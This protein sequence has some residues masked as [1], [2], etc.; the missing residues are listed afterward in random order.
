M[1]FIFS[2]AVL[3]IHWFLSAQEPYA[4]VLDRKGGL[5]SQS[6]YDL[7]QDKT[8]FVWLANDLGLTRYD[9]FRFETFYSEKQSS[10]SG[11]CIQEDAFG[12]VWYENFD[13]HLYYYDPANNTLNALGDENSFGYLPYGITKRYVYH[14]EPN[15]IAAFDL[16]TLKKVK[17]LKIDIHLPQHSGSSNTNFYFIDN[18]TL[19]AVDLRLR[20][21]SKDLKFMEADQKH[22]Y[23]L[24]DT[25]L[26]IIN[27]FNKDGKMFL[28]NANLDLLTSF[29]IHEVS[30]VHKIDFIDD[31]IWIS[32]P[33]GVYVYDLQ[34][35]KRYHFFKNLSISCVIK[36]KQKNYW[37]STTNQGVRI[38]PQLENKFLFSGERLPSKMIKYKNEG[39]LISTKKGQVVHVDK[40]LNPIRTIIDKS[41][42]GEIFY[43]HYDEEQDAISYTGNRFYR[44][45]ATTLKEL[46]AIGTSVKEIL[47]IDEKYFAFAASNFSGFFT[48]NEKKGSD[49]DQFNV[50]T[51]REEFKLFL[52]QRTRSLAFNRKTKKIFFATNNGLYE[53]SLAGTKEIKFDNESFFAS[54]LTVF[55]GELYALSTKGNFYKINTDGSFTY[56]NSE[57]EVNEYDI[58]F[59]RNLGDLLVFASSSYVYQIS[60]QSDKAEIYNLN[61]SQYDINDILVD[62]ETLY[63]LINQGII[64]TNLNKSVYKESKPT[65]T[66]NKILAKDLQFLGKEII[67]LPYDFNAVSIEYS[68]LDFGKSIPTTLYYRVNES[69]WQKTSMLSRELTFPKLEPGSYKIDFKLKNSDEIKS[70]EFSI[71]LPWWRQW[72]FF[73][74][75]ILLIIMTL[76]SYYRSRLKSLSYKNQLLEENVKLEQNLRQSVLT[77]IKSQMNPHFLYNALNTIQAYIYSNDKENAGKYLIKFSKLTR[78]VLD[79]SEQETVGLDEELETLTLYLELEKARFDDD[80][81]FE[82][83]VNDLES[84]DYIRIPPMLI[85]PYVENAV[86]HGLLHKIGDKILKIKFVERNQALHVFVD[87]NGIGRKRSSEL[88]K[89]RN[90]GHKSFA[91]EANAKRLEVLNYGKAD[92]VSVSIEDKYDD[93]GKP[94]GTRVELRIPIN[95]QN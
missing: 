2:I 28:F 95:N 63:L 82:I 15:G 54:R 24:N 20:L 43:L 62:G 61:I 92:H 71:L 44:F 73:M 55:G 78:K 93:F 69:G 53:V 70:I 40:N 26:V 14:L 9:G 91:S 16:V 48:V 68:I 86:K 58:R 52:N 23:P 60:E 41:D 3:L 89:N 34:G 46:P 1:R 77:T 19:Y 32:S 64:K 67:R 22:I 76:Y 87:D 47:R 13:G 25:S 65:F 33:V 83:D 80:F 38:V 6:V 85:Q 36:D 84:Q 90:K 94:L 39:Y 30:L 31:L 59:M 27:K 45:N 18:H 21:K 12:R 75:V 10:F 11:S 74:L 8:G 88:N 29:D 17:T 49:W 72:W 4:L 5:P 50:S 42:Q 51:A 81:H 66:I 7:H 35:N 79:M 57:Y 56:L 37:F